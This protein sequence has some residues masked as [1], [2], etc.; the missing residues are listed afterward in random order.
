MFIFCVITNKLFIIHIF[1]PQSSCIAGN[2]YHIIHFQSAFYCS[3]P[4]VVNTNYIL[5][6]TCALDLMQGVRCQTQMHQLIKYNYHNLQFHLLIIL[7]CILNFYNIE[8][9]GSSQHVHVQIIYLYLQFIELAQ[10][11]TYQISVWLSETM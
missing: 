5:E 10:G 8:L 6:C 1:R 9:I 3:L 2:Y 4:I 7:I 11:C